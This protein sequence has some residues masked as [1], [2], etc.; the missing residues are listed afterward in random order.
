MT[1]TFCEEAP[2]VEFG[3]CKPCLDTLCWGCEKQEAEEDGLCEDCASPS[4]VCQECE[5]EG[6]V[7]DGPY[8]RP[9]G[10]CEEAR[11]AEKEEL[12]WEAD[13]NGDF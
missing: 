9:C 11:F 12:R 7:Q 5:G 3:F 6:T 8:D 1:C 2:A 10:E 4:S 13:R